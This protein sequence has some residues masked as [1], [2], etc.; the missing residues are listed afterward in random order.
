MPHIGLLSPLRVSL[1]LPFVPKER[2]VIYIESTF[3]VPLNKSIRENYDTLSN[4]FAK[5]GYEFIY[6][7]K[8]VADLRIEHILYLFPSLKANEIATDENFIP[9]RIMNE[10]I[11]CIPYSKH[12]SGGFMIFDRK[13]SNHYLFHYYNLD[14]FPKDDDLVCQCNRFIEELSR[15]IIQYCIV[16]VEPAPN[17]RADYNF[18]YQAKQLVDEIKDR[19]EQL[20]QKGISEYMLKK[21]FSFEEN[22]TLSRLIIT[23]DYRIILPDYND[24]EIRMYPLPKAVFFLFLKHSE[25]ILFK[26]LPDYKEELISYYKEISGRE[27]IKGMEKSVEDIV[28]PSL[29][30]IN[31]KCSRIREAFIKHFDDSIAQNYYITG[32]R[33]KPKK[34]TLD[35]K[36]VTFE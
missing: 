32:E 28:N 20:K 3:N 16:P 1:K 6:I 25:G 23:K 15:K 9:E 35:R 13:E 10:F 33:A 7:P 22:S 36:L 19:I 14:I 8:K 2:Q 24:L 17:D 21:I 34:I 5:T 29:N 27:S 18:D 30:S 31:E 11:S 26:N 4:T 12:L